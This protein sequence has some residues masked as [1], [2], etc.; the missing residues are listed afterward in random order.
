M[1]KQEKVNVGLG[2]A[3]LIS[4]LFNLYTSK[5]LFVREYVPIQHNTTVAEY[6]IDKLQDSQID[7]DRQKN[8][9]KSVLMQLYM[10][11]GGIYTSTT[12]SLVRCVLKNDLEGAKY[13]QRKMQ[14]EKK[15]IKEIKIVKK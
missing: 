13:F 15:M 1:T 2:I 6:Y 4:V 12:D 7:C 11:H 9:L 10:N 8:A 3:L 5:E 14:E